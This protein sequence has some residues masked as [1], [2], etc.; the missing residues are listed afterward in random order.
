MTLHT[1]DAHLFLQG[2]YLGF[3]SGS[4]GLGQLLL[5]GCRDQDVTVSL[6]DASLIDLCFGKAQNGSM[7]L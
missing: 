1:D 7:L 2:F 6:Q 3:D 4:I 5:T